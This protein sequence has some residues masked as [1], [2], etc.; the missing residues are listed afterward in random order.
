MLPSGTRLWKTALPAR[1]AGGCYSF[2]DFH[3]RMTMQL[4]LNYGRDR[5][6]L[7]LPDDWDVTVIRKP[8]MPLEPDPARA[9]R[10]ALATPVGAGALAQEARGL[11]SACIL[12]CDITRPVPN[13]LLLP[14]IV[15]QLLDTA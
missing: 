5:Y 10:R 12:I 11:K 13:G 14:E 1:A 6:P 3:A 8:A 9:V 15:R 2:L 7:E 4:D